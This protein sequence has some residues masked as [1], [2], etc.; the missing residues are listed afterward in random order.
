VIKCTDGFTFGGFSSAPWNSHVYFK[1][2]LFLLRRPGGVGPV[3]LMK[4]EYSGLAIFLEES[5]GQDL[6]IVIFIYLANSHTSNTTSLNMYEL[7]PAR[8]V[9][10]TL[11]E[12]VGYH[13]LTKVFVCG[14]LEFSKIAD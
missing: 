7:P 1:I 13:T 6:A 12:C 2:F 10:H 14:T 11:K 3:K 9:S 4:D 8:C 5:S